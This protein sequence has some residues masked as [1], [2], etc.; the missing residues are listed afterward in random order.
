MTFP[1]QEDVTMPV[2]QEDKS[3]G[4][5]LVKVLVKAKDGGRVTSGVFECANQ[6]ATAPD[7]VMLCLLPGSTP[8]DIVSSIQRKLIEAYCLENDIL[9][10]KVNNCE[11]LCSLLENDAVQQKSI[12]DNPVTTPSVDCSCVLVGWPPKENNNKHEHHLLEKLWNNQTIVLP[13]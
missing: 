9:V 3:L 4:K 5:T 10:V 13:V 8:H 2:K 7:H 11:K 1:D 12:N 6:L